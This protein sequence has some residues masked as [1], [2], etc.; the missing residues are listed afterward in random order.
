MD[1]LTIVRLGYNRP[2]HVFFVFQFLTYTS[3]GKY[4]DS[5]R[6][7]TLKLVDLSSLK[8]LRLKQGKISLHKVA[9][10]YTR[11]VCWGQVPPPPL[12]T[13]KRLQ[14]FTTLRNYIFVSFPTKAREKRSGD[15]VVS[16]QQINFE[17]GNVTH[18]L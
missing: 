15:E 2:L 14:N 10:F 9:K 13:Y 1:K 6:E 3:E 17:L 5:T 16:F 4:F 11:L 12:S 8:V 18:N 7:S